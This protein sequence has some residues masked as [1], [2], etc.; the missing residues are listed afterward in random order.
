MD[1]LETLLKPIRRSPRLME[2]ASL[3]NQQIERERRQREQFYKEMSPDE[4][5]EFIDGKVIHHLPSRKDHLDVT[6]RLLKLLDTYVSIH[7]LGAVLSEKCLCVFPRND[8]EPDIVFFGREK[9]ARL[10]PNTIKFPIPDLAV[11]VVSRS[12]EQR[13]RGV[14]F[15]DYAAHGVSEYWIIDDQSQA[16]EQY[17]PAE[18][19]YVPVPRSP[20]NELQSRVVERLSIPV[21]AVFDETENLKALRQI[22][23]SPAGGR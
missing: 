14:K 5:V 12:T 20:A 7:K 15:E 6:I 1:A 2:A 9:A 8:Y 11:E 17:C 22:L 13:D 23:A 18:R 21:A 19:T 10:R 4:K 3:L 16:V